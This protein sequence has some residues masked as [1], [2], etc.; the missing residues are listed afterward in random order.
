MPAAI[1]ESREAVHRTVKIVR[2]MRDFSH[3]GT[4][5]MQPANLNNL[6]ES[7]IAISRS[8][9]KQVAKVDLKLH[10][11]LPEIPMFATEMNQVLLNLI[12]NAGDAIADRF[13]ANSGVLGTISITTDFDESWIYAIVADT[14]CGIPENI[15]EKLFDPFFT[16]KEVGKGTGQGLSLAY[17]VVV[18]E[19]HGH[20]EMESEVGVGTKFIV[21]LPRF[22]TEAESS[23]QLES[24]CTQ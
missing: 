8:R 23:M 24:Q 22:Q 21:K 20:L 11:Y 16:T 4:K 12:V 3:P 13:P 10:H 2:A 15:R 7:S 19:H 9:W 5:S 6:I 1:E 18:N 17:G 14:G